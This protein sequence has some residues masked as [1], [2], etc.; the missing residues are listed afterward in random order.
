MRRVRALLLKPIVLPHLVPFS[1]RANIDVHRLSWRRLFWWTRHRRIVKKMGGKVSSY[2]ALSR[3]G[4][5]CSASKQLQK[6]KAALGSRCVWVRAVHAMQRLVLMH[7]LFPAQFPA[8]SRRD[9]KQAY[10][11]NYT[12]RGTGKLGRCGFALESDVKNAKGEI[13]ASGWTNLAKST[14]YQ[15]YDPC[16]TTRLAMGWKS[17]KYRL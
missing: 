3:Y 9:T 1:R 12:G 13:Q 5:C 7:P 17:R 14:Q 10:D 8:M 6:E 11:N 16:G 4:R 2:N 15:W